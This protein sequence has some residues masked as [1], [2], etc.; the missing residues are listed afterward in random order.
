MKG[1]D[2]IIPL[3][4]YDTEVSDLLKR[5]LTSIKEMGSVSNNNLKLDVHVVGIPELPSDEIMKLVDWGDN[6]DSLNVS[7]NTTNVFFF[8]INRFYKYIIFNFN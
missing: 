4:K 1:I 3:H 2:I 6:F 8:H 5:C 7:T